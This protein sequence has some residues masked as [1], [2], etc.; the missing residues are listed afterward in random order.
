MI[1]YRHEENNNAMLGMRSE[2]VSGKERVGP[3]S[4]LADSFFLLFEPLSLKL[5]A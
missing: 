5:E 2:P 4:R 1:I 3:V